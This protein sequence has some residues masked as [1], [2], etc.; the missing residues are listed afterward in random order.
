MNITYTDDNG[1][2][3]EIINHPIDI[4]AH[5]QGFDVGK[6]FLNIKAEDVSV[7]YSY[8]KPVSKAV[9]IGRYQ[10]FL[11]MDFRNFIRS[12][13]AETINR[14]FSDFI[15][16]FCTQLSKT[17]NETIDS[18]IDVIQE[19]HEDISNSHGNNVAISDDS[20]STL[21]YLRVCGALRKKWNNEGTEYLA[22]FFA[23]KKGA[24]IKLGV[25]TLDD[26]EFIA[27]LI[28]VMKAQEEK[29]R[30]EIYSAILI[31]AYV[32]D[33]SSHSAKVVET[34]R[35]NYNID[36]PV[37]NPCFQSFGTTGG[38]NGLTAEEIAVF[39]GSCLSDEDKQA[40]MEKMKR[41]LSLQGSAIIQKSLVHYA[42]ER[43]KIKLS[44]LTPQEW[45]DIFFDRV[46][47]LRTKNEYPANVD[48]EE[49]STPKCYLAFLA[50]NM[51]EEKIELGND[52]P[53][54]NGL[55]YLIYIKGYKDI[56]YIAKEIL[57]LNYII[58]QMSDAVM[59]SDSEVALNA[60]IE[61]ALDFI[62][63]VFTCRFRC[64]TISDVELRDKFKLILKDKELSDKVC[65]ISPHKFDGGFNLM[66][67]YNII[68]LFREVELIKGG[69]SAI[70]TAIAVSKNQINDK[71]KPRIRKEYI[72][73]WNVEVGDHKQT[74]LN[75][76]LIKRLEA[77]Y[78]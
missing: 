64:K 7:L 62:E 67:V 5:I 15:Q 4:P 40:V 56:A 20:I 29:Y 13:Y 72:S 48:I 33:I 28:S 38:E 76:I 1:E 61:K 43:R 37:R 6:S 70:A 10:M 46:N 66:L 34:L 24:Y 19:C 71:G 74:E 12:K 78:L 51:S 53:L 75:K 45:L 55:L 47:E 3:V 9:T 30:K 23:F 14:V 22:P 63:V 59:S 16:G 26:K 60:A 35:Y 65:K 11:K 57:I 68:G 42:I 2:L 18:F 69:I 27:G 36:V 21:L 73:N 17:G 31:L 54:V 58:E 44:M 77:V 8:G 32:Y 25:L 49:V 52:D 41:F 39:N 50:E